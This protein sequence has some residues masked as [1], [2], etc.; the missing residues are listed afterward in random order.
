MK[1]RFLGCNTCLVKQCTAANIVRVGVESGVVV[2]LGFPG[3][4]QVIG[5]HVHEVE[6]LSHAGD[7]V[8]RVDGVLPGGHSGAQHHPVGVQSGLQF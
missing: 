4:V 1:F 2:G 8:C 6:V 5:H 3:A 7:V